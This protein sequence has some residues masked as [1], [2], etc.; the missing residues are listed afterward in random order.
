[1]IMSDKKLIEI[2]RDEWTPD[3]VRLILTPS[4]FAKKQLFY[5]QEAGF[6][7]TKRGYYTK[8]K[9][10]NSFLIL[11]TL[12]GN[13]ILN[14]DNRQFRL[15]KGDVFFINC[16]L[17]HSYCI[18]SGSPWTF[19]WLHFNGLS[20]M[21]YYENFIKYNCSPVCHIETEEI[22]EL[23]KSLLSINSAK[24]NSNEILS[25]LKI[26]EIITL[27]ILYCQATSADI[28]MSNYFIDSV[29]DYINKHLCEKLTLESISKEFNM[30]KFYFHKQFKRFTNI[31]LNEFVI[32]SRMNL[33]KES[34]RFSDMSVREVAENVGINNVSHFINLFKKREGITP[35]QYKNNWQSI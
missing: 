31:P 11:Q 15:S 4:E 18:D 1:M 9:N 13:G 27:L 2:S 25:S 16:K 28:D 24:R 5:V 22:N 32:N 21:S 23:F 26:T 20:S 29:I 6:F 33:A 8:R 17:E 35:L 34:L 14:Y 30:D 19:N 10:L 12:S 3:S 7:E